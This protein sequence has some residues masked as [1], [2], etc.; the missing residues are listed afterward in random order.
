MVYESVLNLEKKALISI[1]ISIYF[2][3]DTVAKCR[4]LISSYK[5]SSVKPRRLLEMN[6]WNELSF[7]KWCKEFEFLNDHPEVDDTLIKDAWD[8]LSIKD[9]MEI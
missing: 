1:G 8:L 7:Y 5:V 4:K 6:S 2:P 3:L 9:V